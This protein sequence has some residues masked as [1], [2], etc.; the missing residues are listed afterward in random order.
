MFHGG[1]KQHTHLVH[2]RWQMQLLGLFPEEE[3]SGECEE[4]EWAGRYLERNRRH[5]SKH[6]SFPS[7]I[8]PDTAGVPGQCQ[9]GGHMVQSVFLFSA[10]LEFPPSIQYQSSITLNS[11]QQ[12]SKEESSQIMAAL[13]TLKRPGFYCF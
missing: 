13:F 6:C 5:L 4:V 8:Y 12:L 9:F 3:L 7:G 2:H 11:C 1:V 10:N